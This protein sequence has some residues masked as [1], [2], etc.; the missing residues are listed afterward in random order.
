[1]TDIIQD[2]E[3]IKKLYGEF[4][5]NIS[6]PFPLSNGKVARIYMP[7]SATKKDI[8]RMIKFIKSISL[9]QL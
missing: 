6:Y 1:M 7:L 9:E 4:D 3:Q 5:L 8:A 2:S